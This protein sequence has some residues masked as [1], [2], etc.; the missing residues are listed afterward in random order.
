MLKTGLRTGGNEAAQLTLAA[1]V[2]LSALVFGAVPSRADDDLSLLKA[3]YRRPAEI[4]FPADNPYTPEKAALGKSLFFDPRLS[5]H[6]NMN[7]ASC[8]NPSFGW[9]VPLRGAVG[10][11]N[12][13]LP[14][15][16]PTV[17]NQAW[18]GPHF[19]WDGRADSLEDQAKGPIQTPAEMNLPLSEAAS[20]LRRIPEYSKWFKIVFP[21]YGVT[22][23]T[24]VAALATYER[25]VVSSYAPFDA[26]VDGDDNAISASAKRGFALFN[27]KANCSS[28]HRGWNFSDG[29]FHDTG[30]GT[31]DMG[32]GAIDPLAMYAFKTPSLRS[33]TQRA[34]Y[35]HD[36]SLAD[37]DAVMQ[38]Y[39]SVAVDGP[40]RSTDLQPVDLDSGETRDVIEF[41][42]TLTGTKTTV[43][44]PELP[45]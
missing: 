7:C 33:I 39:I 22:G 35:M 41:L 42:K 13:T 43:S 5:S 4:P 34:P 12:T 14:R 37:L 29:N 21:Q 6:Q 1:V 25:T 36:G 11:Q 27:G 45:D 19:F 28:C 9:E 30:V 20:R 26:W 2:C 32:R 24:I 38:R 10:S 18:S 16:S 23:D 44:L 40:P 8:H 17:L 3:S 31:S 15:K